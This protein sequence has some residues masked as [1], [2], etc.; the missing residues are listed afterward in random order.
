M[1]TIQL[2]IVTAER[3]LFSELVDGVVVPGEIGELTVLPRHAP[4]LSSLKSGELRLIIGGEEK[5]IAISGGFMEVLGNKITVLADTAERSEEIDIERAEEAFKVAQEEMES[6]V[7][8]VDLQKALASLRRSRI[9]IKVARRKR[10][11]TPT[12]QA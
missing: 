1:S 2:D 4:L 10:S 3:L 7:S 8:D 12:M 6:A 11:N 5:Y 9:R